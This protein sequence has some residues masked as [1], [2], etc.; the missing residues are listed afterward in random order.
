MSEAI[1]RE[2]LFPSIS[3]FLGFCFPR[4]WFSPS[5]IGRV[6]SISLF[7]RRGGWER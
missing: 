5:I 4:I 3:G 6:N 1:K 2:N 7:G